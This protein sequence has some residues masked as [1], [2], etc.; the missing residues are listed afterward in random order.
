MVE[1][2]L[3]DTVKA[4]HAADQESGERQELRD[5]FNGGGD[6]GSQAPPPA[7]VVSREDIPQPGATAPPPPETAPIAAPAA[8]APAP[9]GGVT[10]EAL[11]SA[12]GVTVQDLYSVMIPAKDGKPAK[13]IGDLKDIDT[14]NR[15]VEE[16][17]SALNDGE[18]A[19]QNAKLVQ[20]RQLDE[21]AKLLPNI[22]ESVVAQAQANVEQH[23]RQ[24]AERL[25]SVV[26]EWRDVEKQNADITAIVE[27][28]KP[29]GLGEADLRAVLR[30]DSR[31]SKYIR[32]NFVKSQRVQ[33]AQAQLDKQ[34]ATGKS[35]KKA[36]AVSPAKTADTRT[37]DRAAIA[38]LFGR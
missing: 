37:G 6:A 21:L 27:Q 30:I 26:P 24:E 38:N 28:I 2:T 5:M 34:T 13:S 32:D 3:R 15:R 29:Y 7:E 19:L 20:G 25:L 36:S 10:L 18:L 35:P 16:R 31:W 11:A 33:S 9:E 4:A 22:P 23:E 1:E 8:P 17:E 12:S 14:E